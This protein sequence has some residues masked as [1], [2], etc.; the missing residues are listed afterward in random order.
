M[1]VLFHLRYVMFSLHIVKRHIT[2]MNGRIEFESA[3]GK[4]SHFVIRFPV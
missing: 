3:S 1:E 2:I 4:G